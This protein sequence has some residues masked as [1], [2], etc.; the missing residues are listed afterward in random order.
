MSEIGLI[1]SGIAIKQSMT[2][3]N[4][5]TAVM[6]NIIEMDKQMALLMENLTKATPQAGSSVSKIDIYV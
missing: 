5:G 4:L 3:L 1:S 6:K 2:Q